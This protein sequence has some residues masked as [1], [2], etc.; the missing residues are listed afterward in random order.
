MVYIR[1][2]ALDFERWKSQGLP[3]WGY[4]YVL[5]YFKKSQTHEL[6]ANAY[7]GGSGPL[8]TSL[9]KT[10]NILFDKFIEAGVQTGYQFTED[11][12]GYQ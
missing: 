3:N 10:K 9:G 12:N 8:Y 5:P 4:D 2:H 11:V 1:G 6:G 7:R